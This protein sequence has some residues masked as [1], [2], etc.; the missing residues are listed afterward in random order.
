MED[1]MIEEPDGVPRRQRSF[2][3]S[4]VRFFGLLIVVIGALA[5]G[6]VAGYYAAMV[7]AFSGGGGVGTQSYRSGEGEKRIAIIPIEGVITD[8]TAE[9]AREAVQSILEK[10]REAELPIV[11]SYGGVA[12]SGGYYASC[13]A[14]RI[15]A[16]PTTI[17]ASIGVVAPVVTVEEL[18][19][20]IG[21]TPE[22]IVA[23]GSPEKGTGNNI[24][25]SWTEQDREKVR[26][27][28]QHM[29]DR[30]VQAVI[31]GRQDAMTEQ[32]V[33]KAADGASLTAD[34]ALQKKLIDEIGY[35]EDALDH[36]REL[37]DFEVE[38][39]PVVTY[40]SRGGLGNLIGVSMNAGDADGEMRMEVDPRQ[41][42]QWLESMRVPR[43][44]YTQQP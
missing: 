41:L 23:P 33:R 19:K 35:I 10:N 12:A 18:L 26:D 42:R 36:A 8:A 5:M 29:Q 37:G 14:D 30:F 11:A 22:V 4:L 40:R 1:P 17:T 44:M 28:V 15:F 34:Q 38:Q 7:A 2:F 21:V 9:F 20:K 25:R 24:L 32:E 16:Q 13:M 39:P 3:S 43:M 27:V 6:T 31:E